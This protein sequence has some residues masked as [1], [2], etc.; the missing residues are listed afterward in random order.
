MS[1]VL[2]PCVIC[3]EA[4]RTQVGK[5]PAE[6]TICEKPTCQAEFERV[7]K[8]AEKPAPVVVEEPKKQPK[9]KGK[10]KK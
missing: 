6:V 2:T 5:P 9:V 10:A 1:S 4:V 3:G 8:A 7:V